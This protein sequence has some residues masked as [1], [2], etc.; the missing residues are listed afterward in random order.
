EA[1]TATIDLKEVDPLMIN[2]LIHYLYNS[3]YDDGGHS[4]DGG[5]RNESEKLAF[6]VGMYIVGDRFDVSN[7]KELAREKFAA[8]VVEGWSG[9]G[10]PDIVRTIYDNTLSTDR[11]LRDCLMSTLQKHKMALR[12]NEDFM[13]VVKTH[14]EFAVELIDAWGNLSK[15]P[16]LEFILERSS[17]HRGDV[18]RCPRCTRALTY[19][20]T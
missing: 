8:A 10:L 5:K 12:D 16:T 15:P 6:N 7:L 4:D 9:D 17:S 3:D 13:E 11:G 2:E 18:V 1:E 19:S 20:I 14:G